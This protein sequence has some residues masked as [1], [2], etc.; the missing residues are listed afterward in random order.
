MPGAPTAATR[1]LYPIP[2]NEIVA[3]PNLTQNPGY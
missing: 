1:N 2:A 3:N